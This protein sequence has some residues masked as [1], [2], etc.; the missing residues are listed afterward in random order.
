MKDNSKIFKIILSVKFFWYFFSQFYQQIKRC[1][2]FFNS[3]STIWLYVYEGES[4]CIRSYIL[5]GRMGEWPSDKDNNRL[6]TCT[7]Y[8]MRKTSLQL[9]TVHRQ[10]Q[11]QR[12]SFIRWLKRKKYKRLKT[13]TWSKRKG[14]ER[15]EPEENQLKKNLTFKPRDA[16]KSRDA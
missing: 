14:R 15:N 5:R 13:R 7:Q 12:L 10:I 8:L 4:L 2:F 9:Y 16:L 11:R 6:R 3:C 1:V